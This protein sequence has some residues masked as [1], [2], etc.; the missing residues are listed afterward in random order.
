MTRDE[1]IQM[2]AEHHTQ[3]HDELGEAAQLLLSAP[4]AAPERAIVASEDATWLRQ[5]AREI[6]IALSPNLTY[7]QPKFVQDDVTSLRTLATRLAS[8]APEARSGDTEACAYCGTTD[9]VTQPSSTGAR[10]C[11]RA[12]CHDA[13]YDAWCAS[14]KPRV[15]ASLPPSAPERIETRSVTQLGV[16]RCPE[17]EEPWDDNECQSCGAYVLRDAPQLMS[18]RRRLTE[19]L[20]EASTSGE[21][22]TLSAG[23]CG[24]LLTLL[25]IPSA[26][27]RGAETKLCP[28]G[29]AC[30][31]VNQCAHLDGLC[32]RFQVE[33]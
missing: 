32:D 5:V 21:F 16:S 6:E 11:S 29:E 13:D 30:G 26:P 7:V 17:C 18:A 9:H 31:N 25:G 23:E 19:T 22:A 27:E 3:D 4:S 12:G 10:I 8:A 1:A 28:D 15:S 33:E 14:Y 2:L 24:A 20:R